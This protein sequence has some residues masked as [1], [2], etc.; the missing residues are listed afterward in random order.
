VKDAQ[1][2]LPS[3]LLPDYAQVFETVLPI[4]QQSV[5]IEL[6]LPIEFLNRLLGCANLY[7]IDPTEPSIVAELHELRRQVAQFWLEL[8]PEELASVY[9]TEVGKRYKALLESGFQKETVLDRDRP[10]LQELTKLAADSSNVKSLN[11]MLGAML[12]YAPGTMK[13]QNAR[14]RL[15]GWL[16][17]DYERVFELATSLT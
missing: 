1:T 6:A 2:R 8:P 17:E 12:Y 9:K 14:T 13:V 4:E 10:F 16:I 5:E 3:W 11:A 15:P 7:Y